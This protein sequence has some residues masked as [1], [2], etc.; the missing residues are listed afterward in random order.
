M[1]PKYQGAHG[2]NRTGSVGSA[3]KLSKGVI[4]SIPALP[5]GGGYIATNCCIARC[6]A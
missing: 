2:D 4:S 1:R 3:F 6:E 5:L